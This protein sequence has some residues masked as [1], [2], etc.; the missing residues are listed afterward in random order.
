LQCS[1]ADECFVLQ[2]DPPVDGFRNRIAEA[3][4]DLALVRAIRNWKTGL[5]EDAAPRETGTNQK[6]QSGNSRRRP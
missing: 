4:T 5:D 1:G 6:N 3:G 2:G